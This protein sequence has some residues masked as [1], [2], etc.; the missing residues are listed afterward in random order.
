VKFS[1]ELYIERDDFREDPPKGYFRLSPG[2]EVRLKHAYYV[3][4][5]RVVKDPASGE[6]TELH[7]SYD[8]DS[9]GGGPPTGARSWARCT[10]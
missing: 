5:T 3:T 1:R 9:R 4:C 7:C 6:V 10:G 2:R 8:P